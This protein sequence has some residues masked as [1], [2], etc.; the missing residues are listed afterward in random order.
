MTL[1]SFLKRLF[2]F[3]LFAV[4][5]AFLFRYAVKGISRPVELP[6]PDGMPPSEEALPPDESPQQPILPPAQSPARQLSAADYLAEAFRTAE[7]LDGVYAPTDAVFDDTTLILPKAAADRSFFPDKAR[8]TVQLALDENTY[9]EE[10]YF[11]MWPRMG[12][13]LLSDGTRRKILTADGTEIPVA[14]NHYLVF[15]S[16]RSSAGTPLF[17]DCETG[18]TVTLAFDGSV[19]ESDYDPV[20]DF[21]GLVFDYPSYYGVSDDA[22]CTVTY[23]GNAFGY[24]LDRSTAFQ[25]GANYTHAYAF[26]EGFGCAVDAQDRLYFYNN[27]GRLRIGGLAVILYGCGSRNDERSLG[28]YY[29]DEGLTRVTKRSYSRGVLL[30]EYETLIDRSG[31]EF[32]VPDDYT[33]Y[34]YSN[35]R[36]LLTKGGRFG[37]MTSRGRWIGTPTYTYAR[38]FFEGL[39]A[40]GEKDGKKGMI[41]RDGNYVIPPVFDEITDC[42]GGVI[43]AYEASVGWQIFQKVIKLPDSPDPENISSEEAS[44]T[45]SE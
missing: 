18:L 23:Y 2:L 5:T 43:C 4:L 34:S 12:Y 30:S 35:G 32:P 33:L 40:V 16:A 26:S 11:T 14:D 15:L 28:Y 9:A 36:M 44:E 31:E 41:D 37:Y 3:A 20:R 27:E 7:T 10:S 39:A 6:A 13:I 29:F 1:Q 45:Q 17:L 21:R 42:S 19:T 38:P 8:Y 25:V 22:A 24:R